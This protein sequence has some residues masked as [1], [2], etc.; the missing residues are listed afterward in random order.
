MSNISLTNSTFGS[1]KNESLINQL[2]LALSRTSSHDIASWGAR[3][4]SRLTSGTT[5]RITGLAGILKDLSIA[6]LSEVSGAVGATLK[7]EL[8]G[9]LDNGVGRLAKLT[10][11]VI[12]S[13]DGTVSQL[14][15]LSKQKPEEAALSLFSSVVGFYSGGGTGDGGI[16][17]LDL[18]LGG[19]GW[20]RSIFTHSII[21][22]VVIETSVLSLLD[23][24]K[25]VHRNLPEE[26]D[27]FWDKLLKY[28]TAS[29]ESFVSGASLG[30]ASHLGIDT[31]VDGFTPYKD[32]PISLPMEVHQT[33][34]GLN[35]G[36]EALH[37]TD[38]IFGLHNNNI[39][40]I[41]E[42]SYD[43]DKLMHESNEL[44]PNSEVVQQEL[45][46]LS[47]KYNDIE[48]EERFEWLGKRAIDIAGATNNKSKELK[49]VIEDGKRMLLAAKESFRLGI[50]GEFRVG[51]STLINALLGQE[52][53]FTDIMEATAAECV[54]HYGNN[55]Y[56]TIHHRDGST[57]NMD[58]QEM[59]EILDINR[60]DKEWLD[61]IDH[62]AYAVNSERLQEFDIWDAPGIG[63]SDDNERLANR[64]LEKL[65]GAIWVIDITLV[66]KASINRPLT[67]LKQTGKP[68]IGVL[69]R[70]DEYDGDI[71][72]AVKFIHKTYPEVFAQI[73]PMSAIDALDK[74]LDSK[75][76]SSVENLWSTVLST[77]GVDQEQ[78]LKTR[79]ENTM[80]AVNQELALH[81]GSLRRSVQD[82]IG[83]CEHIR[84]NLI[85]DKKLLLENFTSILKKHSD[86]VFE[87]IET[88]IWKYLDTK[89]S[90]Q[91]DRDEGIDYVVAKLNQESTYNVLAQ[92][93]QDRV[94]DQISTDWSRST[95]EAI[96]LSR[97]ALA[98][99]VYPRTENTEGNAQSISDSMDFDEI[100]PEA[101]DE[102]YYVGGV[103]AVVAGTIAAVSASVSW[104]VILAALPIGG[105]AA[106]KKQKDLERTGA[107]LGGKISQLLNKTKDEFLSKYSSEIEDQLNHALD[108][109][110][111]KIM[112]RKIPNEIVV[113]DLSIL[114]INLRMLEFIEQK[115][116]V[117]K[118]AESATLSSSEV[119]DR[120]SNLGG[121]LDIVIT[122]PNTNLAPVLSRVPP[123]IRIRLVLATATN[124]D[125]LH[126]VVD[127]CFDSWQGQ[128]KTRAVICNKSLLPNNV[129]GM[130][131]TSEFAVQTNSS[132][133]KLTEES[134]EFTSFKEGRLAAQRMFALLWEGR[135]ATSSN[136][137]I[138][139]LY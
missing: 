88:D 33:L 65:G 39:K 135:T 130:M 24:V 57:R 116:G 12:N 103:T 52:V 30:I 128:K 139:P 7:G 85:N 124:S 49:E 118:K 25:T 17:D 127:N 111:D 43:R 94:T 87:E 98:V 117:T 3:T 125:Y 16:P 100:S 115:L 5:D 106:W 75:I 2:N 58:I 120:L 21:A 131:I 4:G 72:D 121:H 20:H 44:S 1:S 45:S 28:S 134:I 99:S 97:T 70:I 8:S 95:Q 109:E 14:V 77:F 56:A 92:K 34:M 69:N 53:A 54:F 123:D 50:I 71:D 46:K 93:I 86:R 137:D 61:G 129:R 68:V 15:N 55:N 9:Y 59:N 74:I 62:I 105:L 47:Q 18:A 107:G 63:G 38:R 84:Y 89:S 29:S 79:F 40:D 64:F 90:S 37:A 51:K 108:K 60:H 112:L 23:L 73:L 133:A 122:D 82:Q 19:I 138:V 32:L 83:L 78:G 136:I 114:E 36:A 27:D 110:I 104:P 81:V 101:I 80:E 41:K 13:V 126:G 6:T 11:S 10:N 91:K 22:G 31:F 48:A 42:T 26:H 76:D 35:A 96:N 66:G 113:Q 132:L 67:H 102:G 119:L